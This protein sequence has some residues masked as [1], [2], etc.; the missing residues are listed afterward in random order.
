[1]TWNNI[2]QKITSRK[3][4]VAVAGLVVG[5]IILFKA[6]AETAESIG[7]LILT[8]GSIVG[9]LFGETVTDVARANKEENDG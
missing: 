3:F 6:D 4:W 8:A 2:L 1:M 9:Y 5:I 7:G